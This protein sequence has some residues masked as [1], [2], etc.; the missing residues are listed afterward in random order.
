MMVFKRWNNGKFSNFVI[1]LSERSIVSKPSWKAYFWKGIINGQGYNCKKKGGAQATPL[2]YPDSQFGWSCSLVEGKRQLERKK[3]WAMK[4]NLSS[5]IRALSTDLWIVGPVQLTQLS[6]AFEEK[7]C[8]VRSM[9]MCISAI[10][11][12]HLADCVL[13]VNLLLNFLNFSF[14][15]LLV[16]WEI[17]KFFR[18]PGQDSSAEKDF[19]H[20]AARSSVGIM[21]IWWLKGPGS[22]PGGCFRN[23]AVWNLR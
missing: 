17:G 3:F 2:W 9:T 7:T 16:V 6:T 20:A 15:I 11:S 4:T 8:E 21:R 10:I 14:L 5:P 13:D 19:S 18:G 1:S 23:F 22:T 12:S